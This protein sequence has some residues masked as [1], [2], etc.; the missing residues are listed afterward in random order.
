MYGT[1][2]AGFKRCLLVS[3]LKGGVAMK[4]LNMFIFFKHQYTV[5]IEIG[6]PEHESSWTAAQKVRKKK[7]QTV[8]SQG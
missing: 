7:K 3:F 4:A 2:E 6:G 8:H 5:S 1:Y